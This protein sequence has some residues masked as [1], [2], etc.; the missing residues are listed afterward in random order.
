M[1]PAK[2]MGFIGYKIV[3]DTN[4]DP[5]ASSSLSVMWVSPGPERT[6]YAKTP[7]HRRAGQGPIWIG[8]WKAF[9]NA[10]PNASPAPWSLRRP[11]GPVGYCCHSGRWFMPPCV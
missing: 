9:K 11:I 4:R 5:V 2:F 8:P 3:R 10:Y 1:I 7:G 6:G